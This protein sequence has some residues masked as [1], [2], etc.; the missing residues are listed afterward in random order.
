MLISY[1]VFTAGFQYFILFQMAVYNKVTTPLNT[2]FISKGGIENNY[3]QIAAQMVAFIV[4]MAMVTT[5]QALWGNMV[6]DI[7]MLFIGI[8]FIAIHPLW[9]RNIYQRMMKKKYILMEGFRSSR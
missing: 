8:A 5:M 2:K 7:I 1:G 6:S 9:L 3:F 4:P